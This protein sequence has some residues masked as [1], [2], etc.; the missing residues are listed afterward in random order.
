[1]TMGVV[2]ISGEA[3]LSA[4]AVAAAASAAGEV[5]ADC[6][7]VFLKRVV[8]AP[9]ARVCG[10]GIV[11]VIVVV[12]DGSV[13]IVV[14]LGMQLRRFKGFFGVSENR[15]SGDLTSLRDMRGMV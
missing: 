3:G 11:V 6:W 8:G 9:G 7:P 12:I 14:V 5:L 10:I 1:M 4:V 2:F 15:C 13:V